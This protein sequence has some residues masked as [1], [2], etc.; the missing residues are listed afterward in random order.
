MFGKCCSRGALIFLIDSRHEMQQVKFPWDIEDYKQLG[1][2]LDRYK[3][4]YFFEVMLA[5]AVTYILYPFPN[6]LKETS[7]YQNGVLYDTVRSC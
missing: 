7:D 5:V 6:S 4:R 3:D 2:V 1:R